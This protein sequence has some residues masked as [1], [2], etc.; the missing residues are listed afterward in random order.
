MKRGDVSTTMLIWIVLGVLALAIGGYFLYQG[1]KI[2]DQGLPSFVELETQIVRCKLAG[3]THPDAFDDSEPDFLPDFC[4]PC[5]G[6]KDNKP[7][8][9]G[10]FMAIE[11]EKNKDLTSTASSLDDICTKVISQPN[12]KTGEKYFRCSVG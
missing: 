3:E 6:G 12:T 1:K 10:D 11:C 9:D 5:I 8:A 7:Q 2:G 4:D